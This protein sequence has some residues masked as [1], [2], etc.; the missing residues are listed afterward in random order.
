[1]ILLTDDERE[2]ARTI[3]GNR[4]NFHEPHITTEYEWNIFREKYYGEEVAKAQTRKIYDW[5]DEKCESHPYSKD[6][7][8]CL[9][10]ECPQCWEQL[11]GE[12]EKE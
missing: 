4:T 11:R 10:R 7:Q 2:K 8:L 3:A 12:L 1:M 6:A 5:G 9:K